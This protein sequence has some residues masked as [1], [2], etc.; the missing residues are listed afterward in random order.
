MTI[1]RAIHETATQ[2]VGARGS[3]V[4]TARGRLMV[5]GLLF[6][7][8]FGGIAMRVTYLCLW[9][10]G[11]EPRFEALRANADSSAVLA[12]GR[13]DI[14]DRNGVLLATTLDTMS[15]YVDPKMINDA[16]RLAAELK[17]VFPD[18]DQAELEKKLSAKSRF[19]WIRRGL[20]PHEI[21]AVNALGQPGLNFRPESRRFYPQENLVAHIV[22]YTDLDG[23]GLAGVERARDSELKKGGAPLRLTIDVRFQHALRRAVAQAVSDFTAKGAAGLIVDVASGDILA[24]VS[25]PDFDPQEVGAATDDEKFNRFATGVYEMGSTFKTFSLAALLDRV[26]GDVGQKFDASKPLRRAGFTITDYHAQNRV[27]T[28]PEVFMYSSNIGTALVGDKIGTDRLKDFY[29]QLGFTRPVPLADM[30]EGAA[31]LVPDPWRDINTLTATYGHGIAVTPVHLIRAFAGI[32]NGGTLPALHLAADEKD[33]MRARIIRPETSRKMLELLRLVVTHGTGEKAN[34]PG[35]M[36]AGKTGT[37]EKTGPGG[38]DHSKLVSSFIATFPADHPRY[39]ILIAV[40]EPHGN[41]Q[42]YGYATA[43]WVAAPGVGH[44]AQAIM[45]LSAMPPADE[46]DDALMAADMAR[47]I[48]LPENEMRKMAA[49]ER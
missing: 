33:E 15:L 13:A 44:V 2:I 4:E 25:L 43:G 16:S 17:G 37:A 42:S 5:M 11:A 35:A 23:T 12:A 20:S 6:L 49:Y 41:K 21:A 38:Y 39:A 45:D 7:V 28:L 36:L 19:M 18:E 46:K 31:P 29:T 34:V 3:A 26:N 48:H 1:V 27:L 47:Y 40:D 22:G 32:V 30:P 14:V 8:M 24:A 10:Q 9:Q